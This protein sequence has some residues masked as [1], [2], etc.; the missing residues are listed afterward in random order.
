DMDVYQ[1]RML[2]LQRNAMGHGSGMLEAF[3]ASPQAQEEVL[4]GRVLLALADWHHWNGAR[5]PAGAGYSDAVAHLQ[6]TGQAERLQQ[7]FGQPVE[8]PDNGV[9]WRDSGGA[10]IPITAHFE[11]TEDGR[12]RDVSTQAEDEQYRGFAIRLYRRLLATRFRPQFEQ[13]EPVQV[14]GLERRYRYLD[15]AALRRFRSP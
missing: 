15:P 11:V 1:Q 9:F 7:W 5:A 10:G 2:N 13:G 12:V 3:L 6:L 4:R 8:L 14:A